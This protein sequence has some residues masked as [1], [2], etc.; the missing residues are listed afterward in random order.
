MKSFMCLLPFLTRFTFRPIERE[1]GELPHRDQAAGRRRGLPGRV[2][3]DICRR[4]LACTR[5]TP[6]FAVREF[7]R[8]NHEPWRP[9]RDLCATRAAELPDRRGARPRPHGVARPSLA[10]M[11][12]QSRVASAL[13]MGRT[14]LSGGQGRV[15]DGW[16]TM[17]SS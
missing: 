8:P 13:K 6:N 11:S 16:A 2:A 14:S 4:V 9:V 5:G 17:G 7:R 1:P 12:R 10:R 15:T 3:R